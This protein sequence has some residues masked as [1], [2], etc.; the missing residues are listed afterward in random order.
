MVIAGVFT[1]PPPVAFTDPLFD[2][3]E[4]PTVTVAA[5]PPPP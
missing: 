5:L 2:S 1:C 3:V 4:K